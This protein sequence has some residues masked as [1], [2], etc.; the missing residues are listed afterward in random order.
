MR[1]KFFSK[2]LAP[3]RVMTNCSLQLSFKI[4]VKLI[5]IILP[6]KKKKKI[7]NCKFE[8]KDACALPQLRANLAR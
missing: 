1:V 5:M 4:E 3:Q 6:W 7:Q 2:L 8:V